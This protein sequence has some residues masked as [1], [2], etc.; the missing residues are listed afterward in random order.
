MLPPDEVITY[1]VDDKKKRFIRWLDGFLDKTFLMDLA[2]IDAKDFVPEK[3][4][5]IPAV[6]KRAEFA[7][8]PAKFMLAIIFVVFFIRLQYG[9]M[10]GFKK[11]VIRL[12]ERN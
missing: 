2:D 6:Q 9:T 10:G 1:I 3:R 12:R 5:F 4:G 8:L 11:K 7:I